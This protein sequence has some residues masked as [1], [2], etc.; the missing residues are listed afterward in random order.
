[1]QLPSIVQQL[2]PQG[3]QRDAIIERKGDVMVTAGAGSGKTRTLVARYLSLLDQGLALR[4]IIAITF[5]QKAAREMRNRVREEMRKY[6][7]KL[8]GDER[9]VWLARYTELDSARI[10]T[11]HGLCTEILRAHPAEAHIDPRFEVLDEAT[12][13]TLIAEAIKRAMAYALESAP[14]AA[15]FS[16]LGER[17]LASTLDNLLARRLDATTA[18]AKMPADVAS[19]W[20][21]KIDERKRDALQKMLA[22]PAWSDAVQTLRAHVA[23]EPNDLIEL[24]R[25]SVLAAIERGEFARIDRITL[26]GGSAKNWRGGKEELTHV[27]DALKSLRNVWDKNKNILALEWTA[28]D[29]ELARAAEPLRTLFNFALAQYNAFK[30]DRRVLDYDD[31]E[32]RAL[33]LLDENVAVRTRWQN[34]ARAI[35][36][37][38]FQDTNDRQRRLIDHLNGEAG[39]LFLVG[40]AKQS[41]YR[42]RGADV[43]VFRS[44]RREIAN[45]F[46]LAKSYRAHAGLIKSLNEMLRPILGEPDPARPWVEPFEKLESEREMP[47][48]GFAAPHIEFHLAIG[49]KKAGALTV[50]AHALTQRIQELVSACHIKYEH[51]AILC[52]SSNSFAEYENAC[53]RAGIPFLTVAGRGFYDRPEIR[54]VLNA[55]TAIADPTDN[56]AFVGLLR[57]P[58]FGWSD[59]DIYRLHQTRGE[60]SFWDALRENKTDARA[61]RVVKFVDDLHRQVGR[62]SIADLLKTFLD[63]TDYRAAL[64]HADDTRAARNL[65]KLLADA[66][67]SGI[68]SVSE[69]LEW[70]AS[71]RES[72]TREGEARATAEG[73]VQIMSVHAAKG[74]EFPVVV[75]GDIAYDVNDNRNK[76]L[77]DSDLGILLDLSDGENKSAVFALGKLRDQDQEN[78]EDDR[79]LYVAATRAKEKLMVSGCVEIKN[80]GFKKSRGWLQRIAETQALVAPENCNEAGAEVHSIDWQFGAARIGCWVYEPG[81]ECAA[82]FAQVD[83]KPSA[84]L[85]NELL[86]A[87]IAPCIEVIDDT[88]RK[89][90][91]VW[92]VVPTVK[93]RTVPHWVIGKLVHEALAAWRFPDASFERW[94][95]ARARGHGITDAEQLK[96]AVKQTQKLLERF[97]GNALYIELCA[98]ERW[99]EVP[100]SLLVNGEVENG[101]I[102]VL[103]RCASAWRVIDFKTD[104][105]RNEGELNAKMAKEKYDEQAKRYARAIERLLGQTPQ[106]SLCW[107]DF[108]GTVKV[109]EISALRLDCVPGIFN[110]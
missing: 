69:F 40:D 71:T 54:D 80:G 23:K 88:E 89:R 108:G 4:S 92:R 61:Q 79:L 74:L 24:Q 8:S 107:L 60:K 47:A 77:I 18:F 106:V 48:P 76:F 63:E 6:L 90:N 52:R 70:I 66:H 83:E 17:R 62:R 14:T 100:Y 25:A 9:A 72:G 28:C 30:Q 73:A 78:A 43:T 86:L 21:V 99:H 11:I 15:L 67:T 101:R 37:D 82:S 53:E 42:F 5:T 49:T 87:P 33:A 1:M 68:V 27:K 51:V 84:D 96:D 3:Q 103:Y 105:I 38:E 45:V 56:L 16:L 65:A 31:L 57:S 93:H 20:Q 41:I 50:A 95:L 29:D 110:L 2:N 19:F 59:T 36:V 102:D 34:E 26:S 58:V 91:L 55:L 12:A 104:R 98:S 7:E 94:C 81:Y 64:I 10:D 13:A 39:K 97:R 85:P 32:S 109:L 46:T 22:S 75:I 35:L 44:K